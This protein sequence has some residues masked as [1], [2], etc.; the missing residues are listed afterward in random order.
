M[1]DYRGLILDDTREGAT[2]HAIAQLE[3]S[4]GARLPGDYREFLKTCNGA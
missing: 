3:A 1:T 2:E 4:L